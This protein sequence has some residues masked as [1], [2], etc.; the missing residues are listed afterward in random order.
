MCIAYDLG[1]TSRQVEYGLERVVLGVGRIGADIR[2][3]GRRKP[4][5]HE[6]HGGRARSPAHTTLVIANRPAAAVDD[7]IH[8]MQALLD[9]M[10]RTPHPVFRSSA[11]DLRWEDIIALAKISGLA[12]ALD[13]VE[14]VARRR[15]DSAALNRLVAKLRELGPAQSQAFA[16]RFAERIECDAHVQALISRSR[17]AAIVLRSADAMQLQEV[18]AASATQSL[19]DLGLCE[20]EIDELRTIAAELAQPLAELG[21]LY[22]NP[23]TLR[24][25]VTRYW[26][27]QRIGIK[28]VQMMSRR[29]SERGRVAV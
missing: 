11:Y 24:A 15:S 29:P 10:G 18:I 23:R 1:R 8:S 16:Q 4:R 22:L 7:F 26:R 25:K 5:G 12:Q 28:A 21:Q 14:E 17:G 27:L 13:H 2:R 6:V 19:R 3:F 20:E 9:S